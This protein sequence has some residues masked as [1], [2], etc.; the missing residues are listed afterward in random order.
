[1]LLS[2]ARHNFDFLE[3][4]PTS[5]ALSG[6]IFYS[7]VSENYAFITDSCFK[8]ES[9]SFQASA[10]FGSILDSRPDFSLLLAPES[11]VLWEA[12]KSKARAGFAFDG[13][14][15]MTYVRQDQ[16]LVPALCTVSRM[17]L[18]EVK[19]VLHVAIP[20]FSASSL[21]KDIP[22]SAGAIRAK[23]VHDLSM[24]ALTS[25]CPP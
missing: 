2:L 25:H 24:R 19:L 15:Q 1:M 18:E 10:F 23:A 5:P 13:H 9:F 7:V 16:V 21:K 14:F 22:L 17:L 12:I 20:D 8:V 6:L 3:R 11:A 4:I